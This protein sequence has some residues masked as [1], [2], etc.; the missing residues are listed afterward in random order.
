MQHNILSE[1][2][3]TYEFKLDL[4]E[5]FQPEYPLL[6][7]I[8]F[9]KYIEGNDM[10]FTK[11]CIK[12]L[13]IPIHLKYLREFDMLVSQNMETSNANIQEMFLV[14]L[15]NVYTITPYSIISI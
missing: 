15:R 14:L 2:S 8:N 10:T 4:F 12:Y 7:L 11:Y 5:T 9:R 1:T 13:I 3:K 6:Y